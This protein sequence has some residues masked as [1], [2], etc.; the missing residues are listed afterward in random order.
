[1]V[2]SS[3]HSEKIKQKA[4]ELGF[5]HVGIAKSDKLG[6]ERTL[7]E[8]WLKNSYQ[9]DMHWM[10]RNIERR[11]NPAELV[12]GAQSVIAVAYNYYSPEQHSRDPQ[13]GKISRY[14]WGDDYHEIVTPKVR[15]LQEFVDSLQEQTTSR[16]YVDTGPVMEK[17]WAA[18]AGIGWIGK[19][20][21]LISKDR[22]SWLF[23]GAIITTLALEYDAPIDDFC[24]SCTAC[25][26]ACPTD[27]IVEPYIVDSNRCIPYLTIE[28]KDKELPATHTM[29]FENW[30]FG[31]DICQDV[32]PWNR[33]E[34]ATPDSRFA[35]RPFALAPKLNDIIEL[36]PE[37]FSDFF[38][39]SPVKRAKLAGLQRNVRIVSS[40]NESNRH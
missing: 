38:R 27:A 9:A 12:P 19:H 15:A 22:G 23:L 20:S 18:K 2:R 24:G 35:P 10:E 33:F 29:D 40:Q 32:C 3:T 17:T 6:I 28:C 1:V 7:L 26:E 39:K 25:I 5:S 11:T 21:N 37:E 14:A 30:V 8:A 31:C 13:T 4:L 34:T 36:K 16:S